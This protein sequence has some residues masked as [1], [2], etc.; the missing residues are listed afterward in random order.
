M[1]WMYLCVLPLIV[2]LIPLSS[3][4]VQVQSLFLYTY[5]FPFYFIFLPSYLL[6]LLGPP[7]MSHN[8]SFKALRVVWEALCSS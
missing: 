5:S 7:F 8:G 1:I 2:C 6:S 4:S 3:E